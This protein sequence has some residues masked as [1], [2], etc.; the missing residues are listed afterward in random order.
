MVMTMEQPTRRDVAWLEAC[1]Y[2]HAAG[3]PRAAVRVALAEAAGAVLAEDLV[4]AAP[5]P[6]F[7]TAAMDG[8]AV[9]GRGPWRMVG[10]A[11]PGAPWHGSLVQGQAVEIATGAL[12][13][14]GAW[15]V[16]PVEDAARPA[17]W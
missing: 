5:L 7:D 11:R 2:A 9:A 17:M 15:A 12:V 4:A 8:Y 16:L 10:R 3:S 1:A 6:G 13:P 14:A